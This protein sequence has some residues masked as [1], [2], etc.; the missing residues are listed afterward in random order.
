MS[1]TWCPQEQFV[2][3]L[4]ETRKRTKSWKLLFVHNKSGRCACRSPGNTKKTSAQGTKKQN[5]CAQ[6]PKLH[7]SIRIYT[8]FAN[9]TCHLFRLLPPPQNKFFDDSRQQQ[10]NE[11]KNSDCH[12]LYNRSRR[13]VCIFRR[14][15]KR[16]KCHG[17]RKQNKLSRKPQTIFVVYT[18]RNFATLWWNFFHLLPPWISCSTISK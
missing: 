4:Q 9:F 2:A 12:F 16:S 14:T 17:Y 1:S 7:F 5:N 10:R 11:Q 3:R 18:F 6:C 13:Y 15:T 8:C